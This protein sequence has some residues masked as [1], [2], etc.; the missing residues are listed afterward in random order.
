[1]TIDY[2]EV[3]NDNVC[4]NFE[5]FIVYDDYSFETVNVL[6]NGVEAAYI[7]KNT[8]ILFITQAVVVL[9]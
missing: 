2:T 4:I 5:Y 6:H 9:S 1:M 8:F 3:L 7:L